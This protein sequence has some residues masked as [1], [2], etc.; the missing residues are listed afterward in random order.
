MSEQITGL[1]DRDGCLV[2]AD[3]AL[4][5]LNARA[6]G[7]IGLAFAVPQVAVLARLAQRLGV[8]VSRHVLAADGP[9]EVE[10][11]VRAIPRDDG[12]ALDIGGWKLRPGWTPPPDDAR[13]ERDLI[14]AGA[15][16][17]WE[18]DAALR[19]TAIGAS[20]AAHGVIAANLL[21]QPIDALVTPAPD[22]DGAMP[23]LGLLTMHEPFDGQPAT[24][25]ATGARVT[26]SARP[27]IDAGGA[28][29]GYVGAARLEAVPSVAPEREA[30]PAAFGTELDRALRGPLDRIIAN[31]DSIHAQTDGPIRQDY[32]DY[33]ADIASAGRHLMGLV[34][35]L[36]D[37][38]AVER[39]DFA[40]AAE[41][42]DLADIGRR[43]AGLLTVRAGERSIRIDAPQQVDAAPATGE[44]R[45]VLQ[46]LV[47][48]IGN[49][50][51]YSPDGGMVWVRT[52]RDRDTATVIVADQGK[53]IAPEDQARIFDKFERVDPSEPGGSGLG[54]YIARRLARAMGG[55]LSVDSAPGQ[56]ARFVLSLPGP[57]SVRPGA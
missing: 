6:G 52:H 53:G 32:A 41:A 26:L 18:T 46:I 1:V 28:F 25:R 19:L 13:R 22:A 10:L 33:A 2:A 7:S 9:D 55:D 8:T 4:E 5:R 21:G 11:W 37:L 39:A 42:I 15:D 50:V 47:N 45:R 40:P 14:A 49:A 31:A 27:R 12:V 30:L 35:D 29:A 56:G 20:A 38:Q 23:I 54:L 57:L 24:L 36:A 34:D 48:L 16:W 43:A 44:F 3:P 51:R 17:T